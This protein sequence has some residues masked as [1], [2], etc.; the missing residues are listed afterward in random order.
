MAGG[1][2]RSSPSVRSAR[3]RQR[4]F[5]PGGCRDGQPQ[6]SSTESHEPS[7]APRTA[8]PG[9]GKAT[10]NELSSDYTPSALP[11]AASPSAGGEEVSVVEL[12]PI[13][14]PSPQPSPKGRGRGQRI[15]YKALARQTSA[16]CIAYFAGGAD[17][18]GCPFTP[19]KSTAACRAS[20]IGFGTLPAASACSS[21]VSFTSAGFEKS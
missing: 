13:R 20:R 18:A 12:E 8:S 15:R 9:H 14:K 2:N 6:N 1:K 16:R 19:E 3:R 11:S 17:A 21:C 5:N 10:A 7:T 4:W